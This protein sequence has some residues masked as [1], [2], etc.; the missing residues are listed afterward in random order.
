MS[1]FEVTVVSP[2]GFIHAAAFREVS[3][4]LCWGLRELGHDAVLTA[5]GSS[6]L[7]R[8][9][10]VLGSNLLPHC[11]LRLQPGAVL[12]N[13]EQCGGWWVGPELLAWFRSH[14]VW[15]YSV[16][17][18]LALVDAGVSVSAVLPIGYY[19]GLERFGRAAAQDIDVL[20]IGS[21][22]ERRTRVLEACRRA[23]LR[24]VGSY[25][26]YGAERD[27]LLA[28]ARVVL[29]VHFFEAKVLEMV[30]LSYLLANGCTVLSE[31]GADPLEDS[32]L[33]GG[34]QFAAYESL[35]EQAVR[36][37]EDG[38]ARVRLAARGQELMRARPITAYLQAAFGA[39]S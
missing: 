13:L 22:N 18:M 4:T 8:R 6:G 3:E 32:A 2:P 23:G 37:V 20:F 25:G 27:R 38:G 5:N 33:Q 24:V 10:I 31:S 19:P 11:P 17:N 34:V 7:G 39:G 35:P 36:L 12:Y 30:R 14:T 16:R 29:N 15:D 21:F 26:V 1:G 28:R 9:Q